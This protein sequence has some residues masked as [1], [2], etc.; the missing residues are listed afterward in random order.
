M[1]VDRWVQICGVRTLSGDWNNTGQTRVAGAAGHSGPALSK[2]PDDLRLAYRHTAATQS[3]KL[4]YLAS[5]YRLGYFLDRNAA[6]TPCCN[7]KQTLRRVKMFHFTE[8][9]TLAGS[10]VSA[11]RC[12]T[13]E[14]LPG[15]FGSTRERSAFGSASCIPASERT[16]GPAQLMPTAS[17]LAFRDSFSTINVALKGELICCNVRLRQLNCSQQ[18]A[19]LGSVY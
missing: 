19:T 3:K 6:H 9:E 7:T 13:L 18:P 17:K 2:F 14:S 1:S 10:H 16:S 5:T 4:L 8:N 12:I 11:A 15:I